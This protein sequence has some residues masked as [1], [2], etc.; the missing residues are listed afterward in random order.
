MV[1]LWSVCLKRSIHSRCSFREHIINKSKGLE[2]I[3][4]TENESW[5]D[6][7]KRGKYLAPEQT[8]GN[9]K[10][11]KKALEQRHGRDSVHERGGGD[12]PDD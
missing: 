7:V 3:K 1:L 12:M 9:P 11:P 2:V 4:R 10:K 6:K 8:F 5:K